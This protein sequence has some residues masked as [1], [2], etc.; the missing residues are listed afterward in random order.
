MVREDPVKEIL[1]LKRQPG[2][3]FTGERRD[4]RLIDMR[5][6]KSGVVVSD[7]MLANVQP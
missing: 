7:Y 1:R 3:E 6:F 4:F 5:R 2:F